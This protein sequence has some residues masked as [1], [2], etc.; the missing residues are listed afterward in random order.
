MNHKIDCNIILDLLPLYHDNI[1][2]EETRNA[3]KHHLGTCESCTKEFALLCD[4]IPIQ[5][6]KSTKEKFIDTMK[7][8][9]RKRIIS[10]VLVIIFV[11]GTIIGGFYT[12]TVPC[13]VNVPQEEIEILRVYKYYNDTKNS[14]E[15]F[16]L[17]TTPKYNTPTSLDV[18]IVVSDD[19]KSAD[20]KYSMQVPI[21]HQQA[22]DEQYRYGTSALIAY[23]EYKNIEV[24]SVNGKLA[25]SEE[26]EV[27][28]YVYAYGADN[29]TDWEYDI[30]KGI[31][32]VE[33]ENGDFIYWDLDGNIL[34]EGNYNNNR[35]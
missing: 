26:T 1:V 28:D 13:L 15:F 30:E 11:C 16:V 18:D 5:E 35:N 34:S 29:L 20:M 8:Q 31:I 27:S 23:D 14:D 21:I 9:K 24:L 12:L 2:S 32:R 10:F 33:Y 25:W 7:M 3:V 17:F 19:G 6:E 4:N 22:K